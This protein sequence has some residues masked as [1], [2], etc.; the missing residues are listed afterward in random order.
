MNLTKMQFLV[1]AVLLR[2]PMH[3]YAIRQEIIELSGR[4][5]WPSQS[6]V[7]AAIV[8]LLARRGLIQECFYSDPHYWLKAKRGVPYELTKTG[9]QTVERELNMYRE[10][11][12]EARF[13]L[14]KFDA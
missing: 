6:S 10:V 11:I 9:R 2:C 3:P 12:S 7:R 4:R 13:W 5:A 1:L 8:S 14:N